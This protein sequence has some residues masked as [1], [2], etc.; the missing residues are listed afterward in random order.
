[1]QF[2]TA[3]CQIE[4]TLLPKNFTRR[5]FLATLGLGVVGSGLYAGVVEPHW[6]TIGRH[7]VRLDPNRSGPPLKIL[8]LSDLHASKVVSLGFIGEAVRMGLT[9]QP[10]L[11]CLTGDF[12]TRGYQQF[13][14]YAQVLKPLPACA[15]T[16]ACLGNHD[17]GIWAARR[18]GYSNTNRVRDVLAGAGIRLLH[19]T[20]ATI[21]IGDRDL[22]IVGLGDIWAGELQ[23]VIA[24]REFR[25]FRPAGATVV[26]S[27]NPDTKQHLQ[28]YPWNL[29]L[30]GHTHGGQVKL[31]FIG[32]PATSIQDPRFLE[33]L[34]KWDGRWVYVTRGVGNLYGVRFNCPPEVSLITLE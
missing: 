12:I 6:L 26:L 27:H 34:H 4:V 16:F 24:F 3:R 14:G 17:G 19:N 1:V 23:P 5:K 28:P 22:T 9:L 13:D 18:R 33:G 2:A 31:P 15:P 11:I 20:A 21:R 8:H 25:S 32:A 10:D 29:L 30:C 7:T